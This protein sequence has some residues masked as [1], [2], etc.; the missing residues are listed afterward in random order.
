MISYLL[1]KPF[2]LILTFL[3]I[4]TFEINAQS[5]EWVKSIT[6]CNNNSC[7]W[8]SLDQNGNSYMTEQFQRTASFDSIQLTSY[9]I[10]NDLKEPL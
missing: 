4:L 3:F 5:F 1:I 9:H 2:L 6:G 8:I 10:I 7:Y